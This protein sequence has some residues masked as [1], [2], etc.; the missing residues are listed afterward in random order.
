MNAIF[1]EISNA[2]NLENNDD[3]NF[4]SLFLKYKN[5]RPNIMILDTITPHDQTPVSKGSGV[6]GSIPGIFTVSE[7]RIRAGNITDVKLINTILIEKR[8]TIQGIIWLFFTL[9]DLI[10][11]FLILSDVSIPFFVFSLNNFSKI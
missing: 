11:F 7:T 8:K 2:N 4:G 10:L 9:V 5:A 3:R 6:T 1:F